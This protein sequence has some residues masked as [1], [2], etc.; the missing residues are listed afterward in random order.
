M[1]ER[2]GR[3]SALAAGLLLAAAVPPAAALAGKAEECLQVLG[4]PALPLGGKKIKCVDNDPACDVDPTVGVCRVPVG[5]CLNATDPTGRCAPRDLDSYLVANVQPDTDARHVFEFMTLQDAVSSMA[6][7]ADSDDVDECVDPIEMWLPLEVKIGKKKA[8]YKKTKLTVSATVHAQDATTDVDA[9]PIQCVPAPGSDP[10]DQVTSTLQHL[11]KHVFAPT[12][13]RQTCHSGPQSDHS[14]S[15]IEGESHL[16]LVGIM[17][18]NLQARLAGKLRVAAGDPGRSFLLDKLRGD[19]LENEG[20]PMPRGLKK[21]TNG[22][23]A[24]VEAWIAAGAPAAGFVEGDAC[25]NP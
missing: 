4:S 18:D 9:L 24:L 15:L 19:L 8:A 10:C 13:S 11:E 5:V 1:P 12:C 6:L 20:E 22:E 21:I 7:P 2:M 16:N 25:G 3:V 14:L 23:I 17:P